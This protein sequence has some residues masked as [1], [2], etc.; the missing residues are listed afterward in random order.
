M[1]G[2]LVIPYPV[3]ISFFEDTVYFMDFTRMTLSKANVY[4]GASSLTVLRH[5][6]TATP[7]VDV[8]V[9]HQTLQATRT[10]PCLDYCN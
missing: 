7:P 1:A 2:R 6:N 10:L 9:M 4:I 8:V 5:D 3:P